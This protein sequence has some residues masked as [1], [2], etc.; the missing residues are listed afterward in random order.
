MIDY[1]HSQPHS[2]DMNH[3]CT[4]VDFRCNYLEKLTI[5]STTVISY[6]VTELKNVQFIWIEPS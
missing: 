3:I 1:G 2:T 5:I 4:L 6:D